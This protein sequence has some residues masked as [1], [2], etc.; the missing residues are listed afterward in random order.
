MGIQ[1]P[2]TALGRPDD[3]LDDDL[4]PS[5]LALLLEKPQ[6]RLNLRHPV[7]GDRNQEVP[8]FPLSERRVIFICSSLI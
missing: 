7:G 2:A 4:R 6:R 3:Q 1:V 8:P 5:L